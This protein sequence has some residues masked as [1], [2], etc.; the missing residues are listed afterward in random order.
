M[1]WQLQ[2]LAK[3]LAKCCNSP[4]SFQHQFFLL[5]SSY[6]A[7]YF[8]CFFNLANNIIYQGWNRVVASRSCFVRVK[9]Q[10]I[11]YILVWPGFCTESIIASGPDQ[12][13]ELSM[14]EGTD[15]S[16]SPDSPKIFK[17]IDYTIRVF[18]LFDLW[19]MY[20]C[21]PQKYRTTITI[22]ISFYIKSNTYYFSVIMHSLE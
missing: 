10:Y 14:L 7:S 12:S 2:K 15:G 19:I 9:Q 22:F 18:W 1:L 16:I 17:M 8:V 20:G 4:K 21:T 13:N 6:I 3:D 11:K 5:Y